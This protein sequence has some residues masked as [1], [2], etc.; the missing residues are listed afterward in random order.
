MS[1][2]VQGT[3]SLLEEQTFN[4]ET[5]REQRDALEVEAMRR[6]P[7][8][9]YLVDNE[10]FE[11]KLSQLGVLR[12][13][14][15]AGMYI[16]R[17]TYNFKK[18]VQQFFQNILELLFQAAALVIDVIRTF[19]LIVLAILGP[20]AFGISVW[21]GFQATL[22]QWLTRYISIYLWLPVSDLFSAI[23]ARLQ[24]LML[25]SD[26]HKLSDPAFIPDS[27]NGVYIIFMLIGILGY[28]TV[29]TVASWIVQSG[30]G[31][32]YSK[33]VNTVGTKAGATAGGYLGA[34]AGN[35]MGKGMDKMGDP[36]RSISDIIGK[37]GMKQPDS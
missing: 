30:G 24:G 34:T 4:M 18:S 37:H 5:Y 28:F 26:I 12:V 9:A 3:H 25:E 14:A 17:A 7:E 23:L 10:E 32:N 11:N 35:I 29:P 33:A 20:I 6:N 27:S 15:K 1:P 2:I 36:S 16:E 8:T 31:G 21:D 19:F 13:G 22:S